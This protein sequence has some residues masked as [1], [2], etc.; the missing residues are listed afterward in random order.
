[1]RSDT[2]SEQPYYYKI[3]YLTLFD[4]KGTPLEKIDLRTLNIDYKNLGIIQPT[5]LRTKSGPKILFCVQSRTY[6]TVDFYLSDGSG[7]FTKTNSFQIDPGTKTEISLIKIE[8]VGDNILCYFI[9]RETA[10]RLSPAPLWS[11]WIMIKGEDLGVL[12]ANKDVSLDQ[13]N[14]LKISPNPVYA[15]LT[16]EFD[17]VYLGLLNLYN[18]IG[19]LILSTK[20]KTDKEF[21]YDA[22]KLINGYYSIQFITDE[23]IL[24]THF[25]KVN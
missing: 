21:N 10:T 11:S 4:R 8:K 20:L 18:D 1:M 12:T 22:S 2:S 14:T 7:Q 23:K 9:H 25:I 5:L 24:K 15:N 6:R 13:D 16:I 3:K 17:K 19:Q